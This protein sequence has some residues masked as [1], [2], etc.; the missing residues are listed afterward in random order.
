MAGMV[1]MTMTDTK[2]IIHVQ[3]K[4]VYGKTTY[5]PVCDKAKLFAM[6]AGSKTLTDITL[7]RIR[8]LGYEVRLMPAPP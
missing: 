3:Y 5:Y 2:T 4:Q 1:E 8:L 7:A 6:I